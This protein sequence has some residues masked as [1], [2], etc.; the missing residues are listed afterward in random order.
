MYA[1]GASSGGGCC[2]G[3]PGAR[4]CLAR[5]VTRYCELGD[6]P[7][8]RT[9][10]FKKLANSHSSKAVRKD[11]LTGYHLTITA[12]LDQP[13]LHVIHTNDMLMIGVGRQPGDERRRTRYI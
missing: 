11:P 8:Q 2:G 6:K 5:T 4:A 9:A 1:P 13:N 10:Q 12:R 7:E 3:W